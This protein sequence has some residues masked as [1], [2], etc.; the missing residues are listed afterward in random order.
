[1]VILVILFGKKTNIKKEK[2]VYRGDS[3]GCSFFE[4]RSRIGF[5]NIPIP[6]LGIEKIKDI[7]R[8]SNSSKMLPWSVGI[9]ALGHNYDRP[10]ARKLV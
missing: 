6:F 5:F 8:I 4:F 1:M 10:I 2:I 9:N 7:Y 3:A